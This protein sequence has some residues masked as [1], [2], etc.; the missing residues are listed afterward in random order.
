MDIGHLAEELEGTDELLQKVSYDNFVKTRVGGA[1]VLSSELARSRMRRELVSL[2]DEEGEI[3]QLAVFHHQVYVG[4]RLDAVM[5]GDD[6]GMSKR[7]QN[8]DLAVEVLLELLIQTG[9]LN[10][11][12]GDRGL[13]D[14]QQ[15]QR[16][17]KCMPH[18][19][20]AE[21][22]SATVATQSNGTQCSPM[23][24][25]AP[26]QQMRPRVGQT[27]VRKGSSHLVPSHIN[28]GEAAFAN[29]C[30][31]DKVANLGVLL[32]SPKR[33]RGSFAVR[34]GGN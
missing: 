17:S 13:F 29:L 25:R 16:V 12:D 11:L 2:L 6:V 27:R 30:A 23:P 3:A 18:Q 15:Q 1:R 5:E 34:H 21:A 28:L 10:R 24:H 22:F 31:D 20:C 19:E 33:G 26:R 7:L 8:L 32:V 14:L 4:P 9:Q